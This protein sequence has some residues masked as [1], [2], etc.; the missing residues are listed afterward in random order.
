MFDLSQVRTKKDLV[1]DGTWVEDVLPDIDVKMRSTSAHAVKEFGQKLM[2]PYEQVG[3]TPSMGDQDKISAQVFS[4]TV[5]TDWRQKKRD[6]SGA[7]IKDVYYDGIVLDGK[8]LP[9][10]KETALKVF[11][12]IQVFLEAIAKQAMNVANFRERVDEALSGN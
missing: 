12:D 3:K 2:K 6:D 1:E 11:L 4:E 7:I 9:W 8:V 10:S 5:V